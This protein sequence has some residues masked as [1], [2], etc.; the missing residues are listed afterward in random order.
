LD[1]SH[2]YQEMTVLNIYS[3]ESQNSFVFVLAWIYSK[4]SN[5]NI[6]NLADYL[7]EMNSLKA[8][9]MDIEDAIYFANVDFMYTYACH[10]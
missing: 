10:G 9:R 5:K 2:F 6:N 1:A 8:L 7:L 3:Q 4:E